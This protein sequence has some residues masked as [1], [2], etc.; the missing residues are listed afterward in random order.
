[1]EIQDETLLPIHPYRVQN[2]SH[3][4]TVS[5]LLSFMYCMNLLALMMK[6]CCTTQL[7]KQDPALTWRTMLWYCSFT[8]SMALVRKRT[9][10]TERPPLVGEV[11]ANV[12]R[13]EGATWS[14]WHPYCRIL[15]LIDWTCCVN[16]LDNTH[17]ARITTTPS[18]CTKYSHK[19]LH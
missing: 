10:P 18:T 13:I 5:L 19:I 12:L 2:Q 14:A 9:I 3:H 1:M 16:P 4:W 11:S 17:Y 7:L 15:G 6:C 8:Y